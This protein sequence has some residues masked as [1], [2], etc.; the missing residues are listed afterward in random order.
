[1][2]PRDGISRHS[3]VAAPPCTP[4]WIRPFFPLRTPFGKNVAIACF[5]LHLKQV[6]YRFPSNPAVGPAGTYV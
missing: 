6:S 4:T 5:R 3:T 2:V 1:M